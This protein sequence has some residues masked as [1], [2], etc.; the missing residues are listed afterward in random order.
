MVVKE[1]LENI[2]K[3]IPE[4]VTLI[5]VSKTKPVEL[6]KEAYDLGE[7]NF[8]ENKVQELVEKYEELPKNIKWHLIGNL[9]KNKV[10]YIVDKIHLLHSLDNVEL[11][12]ELEKRCA[13]K[14]CLVNALI[15]VNIGREESK[16]GVL[17]ED[18]EELLDYCKEAKYVHIKGLMFIIPKGDEENC[19]HYFKKS[20]Q[21][22]LKLKDKN[23]NN[24]SMEILSMGMTND[25]MW[26]IEEGS[27]MVRIGQGIFGKRIYKNL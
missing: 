20:K 14:Q 4:N 10:K 3:N 15:Q 26:A 22:F 27:T 6:I 16:H 24:V 5:C 19:R 17:E 1:N 25:Y 11:L 2:K 13:Q 18:L 8:G 21:L 9:Q 7:R 12:Q 23:I